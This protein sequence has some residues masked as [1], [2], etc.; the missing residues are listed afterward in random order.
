MLRDIRT[1][2]YRLYSF[3]HTDKDLHGVPVGAQ[4]SLLLHYTNRLLSLMHFIFLE[5]YIACLC[6]H[7][8]ARK[9]TV[10]LCFAFP[11]LRFGDHQILKCSVCFPVFPDW[12]DDTLTVGP[13][14]GWKCNYCDVLLVLGPSMCWCGTLQSSAPAVSDTHRTFVHLSLA[15]SGFHFPIRDCW[16]LLEE[17]IWWAHCVPRAITT[18]SRNTDVT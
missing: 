18:D 8:A 2:H 6:A 7:P 12:T 15:R 5:Q 11:P 3:S 17:S 1:G 13:R 4:P 10:S 16:G 14:T 9:P